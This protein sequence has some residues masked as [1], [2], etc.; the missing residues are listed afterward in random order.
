MYAFAIVGFGPAGM[1][2]LASL[3]ADIV[4]NTLILEPHCAGGALVSQY[5]SVRANIT[6]AVIV[7]AFRKI[8]RWS[9]TPM[10][11]LEDYADNV[12]PPLCMAVKQMCV[13]SANDMRRASYFPQCM[14]KLEYTA[15]CW[16][17]HTPTRIFEAKKVIMCTGAV[18]K[19]LDLPHM[20]IPLHIALAKEQLGM[21]VRPTDKVVVFG[22]SHSGTLILKNLKDLGCSQVVAVHRNVSPFIFARDGHSEGIKQESAII[23]DEIIAGAWGVNKP[24]LINASNFD[25]LYRVLA[26]TDYVIYATGFEPHDKRFVRASGEECALKHNPE[27]STFDGV[28][29]IWGFGIGYPA[30]Y[31]SGGNKYPDIGFAGFIDA[32]KKALPAMLA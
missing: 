11:H 27:T 17:L 12:C 23:A 32:I 22:T 15:D 29:N 31:E 4:A 16:K 10:T 28:T 24:R 5:G 9:S 20:Q 6:K 1:L 21:Q 18:P 7:A 19:S 3:P 2:A 14:T 30:L 25:D 8:A 13:C 26:Q